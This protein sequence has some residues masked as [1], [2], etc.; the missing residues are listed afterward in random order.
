MVVTVQIVFINTVLPQCEIFAF[1]AKGK[2]YGISAPLS[3]PYVTNFSNSFIFIF[4][5]GN[6]KYPKSPFFTSRSTIEFC[7]FLRQDILS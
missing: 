4:T 3:Y 7:I 2:R 1:L 5:F 6:D